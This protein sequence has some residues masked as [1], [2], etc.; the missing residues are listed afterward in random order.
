MEKP[1]LPVKGAKTQDFVL[2]DHL[3]E[4]VRF[5]DLCAH[6]PVLLLFYPTDF[7]FHCSIQMGEM[8]ENHERFRALGLQVVGISTNTTHSHGTW[9]VNL[10][11]PFRLLSDQR[12]EVTRNMG[13]MMP[14]DSW[15]KGRS[16][17]AAFLIDNDL[18]VIFAWVPPDQSIT[19]DIEEL[20]RGCE[21][22]LNGKG[23]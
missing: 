9:M 19:P 11:I 3:N 12:G 6:R 10:N 1:S 7:G 14:D 18:T 2:P 5:S 13:M 23:P 8:R 15:L 17:R 4:M 21:Q 22:A 20:Y 16:G